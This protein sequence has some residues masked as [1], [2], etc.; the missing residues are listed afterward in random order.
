[1]QGCWLT[2][3][4]KDLRTHTHT[5]SSAHISSAPMTTQNAARMPQ[6]DAESGAAVVVSEMMGA[7]ADVFVALLPGAAVV[8]VDGVGATVVAASVVVVAASVVTVV[9]SGA[10][11]VVDGVGATVVA[12]SVVVVA[13]SVVVVVVVVVSGRVMV[14]RIV[15]E[16]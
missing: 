2:E 8:V 9:V 13:A 3:K 4:I 1:M 14:L 12:A 15:M 10:A 6:D 5:P 7:G 11:V 16:C